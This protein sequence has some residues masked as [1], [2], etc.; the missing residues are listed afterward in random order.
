M[1][2]VKIFETD[3]PK[4]LKELETQASDFCATLASGTPILTELK[5]GRYRAAIVVT[6]GDGVEGYD[7]QG[8]IKTVIKE[9][10]AYQMLISDTLV[11]STARSAHRAITL[12]AL[13]DVDVGKVVVVLDGDGAAATFNV[14]V[15]PSGTNLINGANTPVTISSNRGVVK[16]VSLGETLG[17]VT[18]P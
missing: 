12:P 17:W 18:L 2:A 4:N 1:G 15:T 7:A 9:N 14:V 13:A 16:Y 10:V 8:M 3:D 11:A 5:V 6:Y